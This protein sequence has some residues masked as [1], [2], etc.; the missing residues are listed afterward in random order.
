MNKLPFYLSVFIM[1][2]LSACNEKEDRIN[3]D[4]NLSIDNGDTIYFIDRGMESSDIIEDTIP[5]V[6][7]PLAAVKIARAVI[8]RF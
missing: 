4:V 7:T 3:A 5:Y 1:V 2:F 8:R 6:K